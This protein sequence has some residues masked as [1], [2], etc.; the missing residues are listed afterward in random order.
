MKSA[1]SHTLS[2]TRDRTTAGTAIWNV[3]PD[4]EVLTE[5]EPSRASTMSL[6]M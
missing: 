2:L 4:G 6:A 1:T 3:V 5:I